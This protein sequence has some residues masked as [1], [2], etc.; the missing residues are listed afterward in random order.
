MVDRLNRVMNIQKRIDKYEK[1]LHN[2]KNDIIKFNTII[3]DSES[4]LRKYL[5]VLTSQEFITF[6][7]FAGYEDK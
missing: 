1:K 5:K 7:E 2:Y 6:A 4:K 3:K